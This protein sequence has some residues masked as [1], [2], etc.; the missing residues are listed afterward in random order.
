[1]PAN[2]HLSKQIASQIFKI[3]TAENALI[4]YINSHP[5]YITKRFD[6]K[7]DSTK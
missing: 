4:F 2:E 1:M 3:E 7:D 5:A 6:V